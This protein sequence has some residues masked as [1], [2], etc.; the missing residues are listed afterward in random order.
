[1]NER[2][3]QGPRHG[4]RR[5]VLAARWLRLLPVLALDALLVVASY[6][7]ALA[8]RFDGEIPRASMIFF[9]QVIGFIVIA[10][11][12]SNYC[13]G[14]YRTAW[15]YAGIADAIN[16]AFSVGLV[17]IILLGVNVFLN[18][19]HIPLTTTGVAPAL[20]FLS[21]GVAKL[22]P[23]LRAQSPFTSFGGPQR[24]VLIAGAGHTGQMLA[25]EFLQHPEWQ[26]KPIG[27]VDDDAKK[28]GMRI[29][30]LPVFGERHDIPGL[31]RERQVEMVALAMPSASGAMIRDY[32]GICQQA[33]VPVRTV[34]G[35]PEMVHASTSG[36]L[37]E[38]TVDDLLGRQEMEIDVARCG[39]ALRGRE[40]L[41][42]G[43]AGYLGHELARQLLTFGPAALHLLDTNESGVFEM[44]RD[45]AAE[46]A[47]VRMWVTDISDRTQVERALRAARPHVIFHTAAY[48]NIPVMEEHPQAALHVNVVGTMN[49]CLAAEAMGVER[50]IFVSTNKAAEIDSVY[51]ATKRIGEL[52]VE[53]LAER[54][55]TVF[56]AV[57]L[58][59]VMGSRGSVVPLFLRQI[60]RGGPVLLS[61]AEATRYFMSPP[62][63]VRLLV[64]AAAYARP[65]QVFVL[66]LGEEV[67]IADLAEK[68]IRL[69]GYQPGRD[70]QIVY[71]GLRPGEQVREEPLDGR[72]EFL[73]TDHKK[74][75]LA[76]GGPGCSADELIERIK[77]LRQEPPESRDELIA[78]LH[79]LA[80]LDLRDVQPTWLRAEEG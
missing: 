3:R 67:K 25:R 60:E 61:H 27:Y 6:A 58:H 18:P 32:V 43:A 38:I 66:D 23:R 10:Y 47:Q 37:R 34:L 75:F 42:T 36:R 63:A 33:E 16:L 49:L 76:K 31:V 51:G 7:A 17:S 54:S 64:Q 45:L 26:Y 69:R 39:E 29:H 72:G 9:G 28:R 11:L 8:L 48:K 53:A 4:E 77:A 1:M 19:R 74:I 13:F 46:G 35:V 40:I 2:T 78:R 5:Q 56:S 59:N 80:R 73:P 68:L 22:W 50:F 55:K 57:R 70:I 24:Q 14:I 79:A 15:Q 21:M 41:I 71:T 65:G 20:I 62:E 44:Q 52:L 30:G 12:V